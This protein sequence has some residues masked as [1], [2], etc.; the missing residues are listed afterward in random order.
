MRVRNLILA[1]ILA[2]GSVVA[3]GQAEKPVEYNLGSCGGRSF[4]VQH[5]EISKDKL[6]FTHFMSG[7]NTV[8]KDPDDPSFDYEAQPKDK[9][10]TIKFKATTNYDKSVLQI[11]GVILDGRLVGLMTVDGDLG[12]VYYGQL[13]SVDD[14]VKVAKEDFLTCAAIH[15]IPQEEIPSLLA[16]FLKNK[17]KDTAQ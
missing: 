7:P 8:V 1:G 17:S 16:D 10:G 12:H 15:Q 3:F 6:H 9:D 5:A 2:V 14:M 4:T 11:N 13:G